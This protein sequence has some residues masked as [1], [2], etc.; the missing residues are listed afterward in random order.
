[1]ARTD[2][3]HYPKPIKGLFTGAPNQPSAAMS[4]QDGGVYFFKGKQYWHLNKQ[5]RVQKGYPRDIAHNWMHC[6]PQIPDTTP[7]GGDTSPSATGPDYSVKGTTLDTTLSS[8][9]VTLNTDHSPRDTIL[10]MTPSATGST[11][12][13]FPGSITLPEAKDLNQMSTH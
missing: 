8:I 3:S 10:A 13:S 9:D 1:M 2:F 11:T 7:S 4:R 12:L 5:L 6:H